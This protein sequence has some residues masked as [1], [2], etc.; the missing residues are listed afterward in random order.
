MNDSFRPGQK[1]YSFRRELGAKASVI[2]LMTLGFLLPQWLVTAALV[3]RSC[4]PGSQA[5]A[6]AS[7]GLL[8]QMV[9]AALVLEALWMPLLGAVIAAAGR[10]LLAPPRSAHRRPQRPSA[11]LATGAVFYLGFILLLVLAH[12]HSLPAILLVRRLP[13]GLGWAL[14]AALLA[15]LWRVGLPGPRVGRILMLAVLAGMPCLPWGRLPI[16]PRSNHPG[17]A[18]RGLELILATA[19]DAGVEPLLPLA[20]QLGGG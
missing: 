9:P 16:A 8:G 3:V 19:R 4:L 17:P 1:A 12:P 15:L 5:I 20:A 6:A 10:I 13:P 11:S 14:L 18:A 2:A 7:H